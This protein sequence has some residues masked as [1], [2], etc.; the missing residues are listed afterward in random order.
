MEW[1]YFY[2][3]V[4]GTSHISSGTEKQDNCDS[5]MLNINGNNYL[6]SVV[7]DGAG[8]AK[9]SDIS[10][11]Y[12][13]KL[14]IRKTKQWLEKDS[15]ENLSREV[16]STWFEYFQKVIKR[17]V[18]LYKLETT[19]DFA[20]TV[21]YAL[22]SENLNIFVQIG[23]G[24]IAISDEQELSAVFLPQNG[25]FINTTNFATQSNAKDI[26]MFKTSTEHVKQIAM[27]TDGIEQIAFDF[28]NQKPFLPFFTMFFNAIENV[29]NIGYSESLSNQL[30]KFLQSE[31]V[32]KKTDDDKTLFI[33]VCDKVLPTA[34]VVVVTEVT[35]G[36][37]E[38]Q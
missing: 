36:T 5:V 23:D 15:I 2:S 14:F 27:H 28:A 9:H 18:S 21:L 30:E 31:R 32:N 25:E 1:K 10:S 38:S 6:V 34:E 22:L 7:A 3:T 13:C 26:F 17:L 35:E 8:S 33:A 4:K 16:V 19:R 20:T 37:D 11:A 24:I 12:V 29:K